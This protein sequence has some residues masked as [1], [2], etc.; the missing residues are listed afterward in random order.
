MMSSAVA[1]VSAPHPRGSSDTQ[2]NAATSSGVDSSVS[3]GSVVVVVP[4]VVLVVVVASVV[5]VDVVV[6]DVVVVAG[7]WVVPCFPCRSLI[8]WSSSAIRS[9]ASESLPPQAAAKRRTASKQSELA[10]AADPTF[11]NSWSCA[12]RLYPLQPARS[13]DK[14]YQTAH[15]PF[16]SP[17]PEADVVELPTRYAESNN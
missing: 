8:C 14:A 4:R 6:V 3:G 11:C 16:L 15:V 7:T 17:F 9:S 2:G 12:V 1:S 10:H 5:V 13:I